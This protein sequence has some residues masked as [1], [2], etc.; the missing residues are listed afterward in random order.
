MVIHHPVAASLQHQNP[1]LFCS[2]ILWF[3]WAEEALLTNQV[4]IF[5]STFTFQQCNP[6]L[7]L[8]ELWQVLWFRSPPKWK[9]EANPLTQ[10]RQLPV[11]KIIAS[12]WRLILCLYWKTHWLKT[13]E[14]WDRIPQLWPIAMGGVRPAFP[15]RTNGL[16]VG[17]MHAG[18]VEY[19]GGLGY[20]PVGKSCFVP[21]P[22][23]GEAT[24]WT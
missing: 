15:W 4:L 21:V 16:I 5:W 10:L 18:A 17:R 3:S 7:G 19:G 22:S 9:E 20:Q 13:V 11:S 24:K 14:W 1:W 2:R 6:P 12:T 8:D 23:E